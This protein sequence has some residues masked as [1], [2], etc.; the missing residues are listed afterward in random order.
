MG[1]Q[2]SSKAFWRLPIHKRLGVERLA[3]LGSTDPIWF[4][5]WDDI[6]LLEREVS[7]LEQNIESIPFHDQLKERWIQNLRRCL[8]IL[9][10]SAP[11]DS[12]PEFMIG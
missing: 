9:K 6:S 5:G 10:Q 12:V 7:T 4:R 3:D 11:P 8:N 2:D 1:T